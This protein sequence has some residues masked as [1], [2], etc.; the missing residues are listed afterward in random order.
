M[1]KTEI[2]IRNGPRTWFVRNPSTIALDS[3][4]RWQS[5]SERDGSQISGMACKVHESR[6]WTE[7][8]QICHPW[9]T[10]L[11]SPPTRADPSVRPCIANV[12]CLYTCL[13]EYQGFSNYFFFPSVHTILNHQI[14]REA[15]SKE[16]N[17]V[18]NEWGKNI[19]MD[20]NFCETKFKKM[21]DPFE[22][23]RVC[24]EYFIFFRIPDSLE[25]LLSFVEGYSWI[26][27][28]WNGYV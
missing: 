20:E 5:N 13:Y 2:T 3:R 7:R 19:V 25:N 28:V 4:V 1:H 14:I 26:S 23:Y 24:F 9:N 10:P 8:E 21:E 17:D 27:R 16:S 18:N 15:I 6:E 22:I 11:V 12:Y